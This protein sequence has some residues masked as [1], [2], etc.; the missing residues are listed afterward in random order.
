MKADPMGGPAEQVRARHGWRRSVSSARRCDNCAHL[1]WPESD[2]R[3]SRKPAPRCAQMAS[4]SAASLGGDIRC[5][6]ATQVSAVCNAFQTKAAGSVPLS[7]EQ[8]IQT[9]RRMAGD[10]R[11]TP[12]ERAD[13]Q[14]QM[15]MLLAQAA[16]S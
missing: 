11:Y 1:R 16:E 15:Q 14:Y 5:M 9:L 2:G 8:Q 10:M 4:S 6:L 7:R 13:A 3:G 12:Q